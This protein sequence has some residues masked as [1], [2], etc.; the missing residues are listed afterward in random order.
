MWE[1]GMSLL[2]AS[3]VWIETL[4]T[5]TASPWQ[6]NMETLGLEECLPVPRTQ[7]Q[8]RE[9]NPGTLNID[10]LGSKKRLKRKK[11][12]TKMPSSKCREVFPLFSY[13]AAPC[14]GIIYT[15]RQKAGKEKLEISQEEGRE[16]ESGRWE[17]ETNHTTYMIWVLKSKSL[18]HQAPD[19]ITWHGLRVTVTVRLSLG[20]MKFKG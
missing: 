20:L 10:C 11:N 7:D 9:P 16:G 15:R 19:W 6:S 5:N 17:K 3:M 14:T 13:S 1:I 18:T 4:E 8:R 12:A 2:E